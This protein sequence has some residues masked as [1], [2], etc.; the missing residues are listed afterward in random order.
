MTLENV[1]NEYFSCYRL[2]KAQI[3]TTTGNIS[4]LDALG[5]VENHFDVRT[6]AL[7]TLRARTLGVEFAV[8]VNHLSTSHLSCRIYLVSAA[9]NLL[10]YSIFYAVHAGYC[11]E[12]ATHFFASKYFLEKGKNM[13]D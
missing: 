4:T 13:I 5:R 6:S 11:A 2:E 7:D 12:V 3:L 9:D 1:S 8:R 10:F